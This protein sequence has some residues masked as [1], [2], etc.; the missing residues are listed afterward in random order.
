MS[1]LHTLMT[2]TEAVAAHLGAEPAESIEIP[3]ET[4]EGLPGV[5]VIEHRQRRRVGNMTWGFPRLTRAMREQGEPPGRI[6]LVADLTNPLWEQVVVDPRR[7]C[8]IAITH[9]ANPDGVPGE[10]TRTWFSIQDQPIVAWAGFWRNTPDGPVFAG[11]TM[12]ANEAVMPTND[13]M[14]VLLDPPE[15]DRWLH[16]PIEDVIAFQFRPP[17]AAH[18]MV[19]EARN[20]RWRSDTLPSRQATLL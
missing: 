6:G 15:Y 8:L 7:R 18:R 2:T 19:T 5:V 1:R 3:P 12:T 17:C 10:M 11:M 14:P 20:G 13:R 16:G 4:I 9:F